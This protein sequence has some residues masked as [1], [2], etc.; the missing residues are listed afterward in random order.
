MSPSLSCPLWTRNFVLRPRSLRGPAKEAALSVAPVR[1][2]VPYVPRI[3]SKS[4]SNK[5]FLI[6]R[7]HRA[8]QDKRKEHTWGLKVKVTW[9]E[10]KKIVFR[11]YLRRKWI[12]LRHTKKTKMIIGPLYTYRPIYFTSRNASFLWYCLSVCRSL[13]RIPFVNSVLQSRIES[14][15]FIRNLLHN[16]HFIS[17]QAYTSKLFCHCH[18]SV[19]S[20]SSHDIFHKFHTCR[21][22]V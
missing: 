19:F 6:Y 13:I 20:S 22:T 17:T 16:L 3:F 2:S 15:Y 9:N 8:G 18:T 5:K 12:D 10:N 7:K 11:A 4:E 14:L 1:L 21:P